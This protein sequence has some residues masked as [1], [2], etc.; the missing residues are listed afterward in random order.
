MGAAG[1]RVETISQFEAALAR[2]K[3]SEK[4]YLIA[5]RVH[6]K[7]WTPGDAWWDVGAP[8][9]SARES[10]REA[11]AAHEKARVDQRVGV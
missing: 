4:T 7:K 8:E 11:R 1:E 10:I 3:Q 9:V 2:A 6:P 5:L